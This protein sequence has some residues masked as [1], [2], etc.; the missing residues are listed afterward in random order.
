MT[1]QLPASDTT[2]DL[3][4]AAAGPSEN[5]D[6]WQAL[7]SQALAGAISAPHQEDA[8]PTT[9]ESPI[10]PADDPGPDPDLSWIPKPQRRTKQGSDG[11]GAPPAP[12]EDRMPATLDEG[13]T[14]DGTEVVEEW[15]SPARAATVQPG[16]YRNPLEVHAPL[17]P[18]P[19]LPPSVGAP[20]P[21]PEPP[22]SDEEPTDD[23]PDPSDEA[24]RK[25][26]VRRRVTVPQDA[27][28]EAEPEAA[29]LTANQPAPGSWE[30]TM[31]LVAEHLSTV[32]AETPQERAARLYAER[33]A[34]YEAA[35]ETPA[36]RKARH[37]NERV[38]REHRASMIWRQPNSERQKRFRR[39]CALTAASATLGFTIGAVQGIA[40]LPYAVALAVTAGGWLLDTWCRRWGH[41]RVSQITGGRIAVLIVLRIPVASG[42]AAVLGL[43]PLFHLMNK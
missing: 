39:W 42:L 25:N 19:T 28:Q 14:D 6:W 21:P 33:E 26:R 40:H 4:D 29:G 31:Y 24:P 20:P 37:R 16:P 3:T 23:D 15:W 9:G 11:A 12:A 27:R 13:E 1:D 35:G 10:Q 30:A 36:Q 32:I 5:P 2:D 7:T 22:P 18:K 34:R 41:V 17:P 8:P 43:A 38:E